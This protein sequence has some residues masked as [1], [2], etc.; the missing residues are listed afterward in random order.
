MRR[1]AF[2]TLYRA[3]PRERQCVVEIVELD[4]PAQASNRYVVTLRQG[5]LKGGVVLEPQESSLTATPCT[6]DEALRR[7]TDFIQRRLAA[8]ERL[9]QHQGLP[10]L[11][12]AESLAPSSPRAAKAPASD[13]VPPSIAALV[14]RFAPERWQLLPASQRSRAVWRVA[15]CSDAA[16]GAGQRALVALVPRLVEL[17]E[18]GDD[19][20]DLCIAVALARLGDGGAAV[21]MQALAGRGRSPATRRA[22]HQAWL[23]L[24]APDA[25]RAHAEGLLPDWQAEVESTAPAAER[26]TAL[27]DRVT[28]RGPGWV[29]LLGDWY[30][31]ALVR[32]AARAS[33]LALLA[34]LPLQPGPFQA[35]RYL[36][37]AAEIRR[38]APVLGLLH[39]RFETTR[40]Y[41]NRPA[42]SGNGFTDPATQRWVKTPIAKELCQPNPRL[43]YGSATRD[44]LRLRGWRTLRRLAAIGHS[45]APELSVQLL[46][47]LADD[48][49]PAARVEARWDR[50]D[51]Q[52]QRHDRHYH[53]A[54]YWL[55]VP[56][57]LLAQAPGVHVSARGKRWW[58]D[59]PLDTSAA[60]P[61]RSEGLQDM[62]NA[63]PEAL[64]AL[65]LQSRSALVHAVVARALQ[66]HAGFVAQ[67]PVAV[68]KELLQSAH[69]P[70]ARVG[71]EAVRARVLAS[72]ALQ[73]QVPW[74]LLLAQS[75]DGAAREFAFVHIASDPAGFAV[76]AELVVA[77]LLSAHERTRRQGQGLA[78]IASAPAL[79]SELQGALLAA[80]ADAPGLRD[81]LVLVEQLLRG[82]LAEAAAQ[83]P[84]EALL[85]LLDHA[86]AAVLH[87]AVVWL[88][89]HAHGAALVAPTT[90]ARLLVDED[91]YRRA[92]GVR[93]LAA[94]PDEVLR[95]Q[96]ELLGDL[97]VSPHAGIREALAPALQRLAGDPDFASALAARLHASLFTSEAGEG[98]HEDALRWLTTTLQPHAPAC[99]A[100]G[101]WR[102]LHAQSAGAQLYGAWA[103]ASLPSTEFSLKQQATL[104]RHADASVR[105]WAM[106]AIDHTLPAVPS[107]EQSAQLLPLADTLF[108]DARAY[109]HQLF[110]E[111]LPDAAL[112][113]ELLIAWVDHPQ[114]W[115]QALGRTRLVRRM[116]AG[117]ASL[118]L[119]RLSQ[120]P[121]A[122]VQLFVTQ[123][124][125]E[126][127]RDDDAQLAAR[128]RELTPYFLTVLSQVNRGR[129]A[130]SRITAF[131]REASDAPQAAAVVAEIFARQV[132]TCS[133]TDKPQYIA[134][135]R[136]IAAR[137]PQIALPFIAWAPPPVR[138][139]ANATEGA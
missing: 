31:L 51:G 54:A 28:A 119:T 77:L 123:W 89:L 37:K 129:V 40:A 22:A 26:A 57:L 110:A 29:P 56:K 106:A 46:L 99:D 133:L 43:A 96:A 13:A 91:P 63:H 12:T 105:A 47:G 139:A 61:Q 48:A 98:Q 120:H 83:A 10:G 81:G 94:L 85:C 111:R 2:A 76:H 64:L 24:Q 108:D 121:S 117:E 50:V 126:L 30:D 84:T 92:S 14:A 100:S 25:L 116:A 79:V 1:I 67:Q 66:D 82:P 15:E 134:G 78:L 113:P 16:G 125:L 138:S 71:F 87:L 102:A 20:L 3:S 90:L 122:S 80:D 72:S 6:L 115:V 88:L 32:P 104:A 132:V 58:T 74:L 70:T 59:Q 11:S 68:L 27:Q 112:T 42:Y 9:Q 86:D 21:A 95:T 4:L 7:A 97:A 62:W 55:L 93:L 39:A 73:D 52:Y 109:A 53:Q 137:H 5:L 23:M 103:L 65:A 114:P 135:L 49:L 107:P 19:L 131:L 41:F 69:A 34:E 44:Y 36:Y 136:D 38:D 75:S 8:G 101:A 127:P 60:L 124:L 118:C 18:N 33:L 35:L 130:K 45:H 128:L 17:L